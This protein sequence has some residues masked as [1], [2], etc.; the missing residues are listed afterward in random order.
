MLDAFRDPAQGPNY[1]IIELSS[2]ELFIVTIID[3]GVNQ[4]FSLTVN[5]RFPIEFSA[6]EQ[7][8]DKTIAAHNLGTSITLSRNNSHSYEYNSSGS[9]LNSS[10]FDIFNH[11]F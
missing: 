6:P 7:L 9:P 11:S 2:I 10:T 3:F 4:V 1:L 5:R 8:R